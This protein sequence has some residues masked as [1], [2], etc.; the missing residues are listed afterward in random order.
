[1]IQMTAVN[2]TSY[3]E[4]LIHEHTHVYSLSRREE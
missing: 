2:Q 3:C 4:I 1:M